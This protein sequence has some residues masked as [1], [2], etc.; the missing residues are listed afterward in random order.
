MLILK[1][2]AIDTDRKKNNEEVLRTSTTIVF[3]VGNYVPSI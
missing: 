1:E 3:V 2:K